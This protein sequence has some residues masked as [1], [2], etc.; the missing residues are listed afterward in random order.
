MRLDLGPLEDLATLD[1]DDLGAGEV[2]T[3][4][5][6]PCRRVGQHSVGIGHLGQV[7][8][9]GARLLARPTFDGPPLGSIG[10]RWLG[11]TLGRGRHGRVARVLAQSLL[12]VG[13]ARP[14]L[15]D[16]AHLLLDD[17]LRRRQLRAQLLM[18]GRRVIEGRAVVKWNCERYAWRCYW[19][20][21]VRSGDLIVT[22]LPPQS[23][24]FL[25]SCVLLVSSCG[26]L[27]PQML[28]LTPGGSSDRLDQRP[29]PLPVVISQAVTFIPARIGG[30]GQRRETQVSRV[31]E[32]SKD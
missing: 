30:D 4:V 25:C 12:E 29:A 17:E 13:Q 16:L 11:W 3:T 32:H 31:R 6:A 18:R 27:W 10:G 2:G 26:R 14:Q 9:L 7:L 28:G 8:A 21:T 5:R 22:H 20:W 23:C 1:P 15:S 19:G 24:V